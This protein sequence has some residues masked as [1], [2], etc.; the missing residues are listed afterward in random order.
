M[1]A[2][3]ARLDGRDDRAERPAAWMQH[4]DGSWWVVDEFGIAWPVDAFTTADDADA[5]AEAVLTAIGQHIVID[6]EPGAVADT[7]VER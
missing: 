5:D 2:E 7:E 1:N 3:L 6:V 4:E